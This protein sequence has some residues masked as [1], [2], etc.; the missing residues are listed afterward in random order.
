MTTTH[1]PPVPTGDGVPTGSAAG[2][3]D[4]GTSGS[5]APGVPTGDAAP[6][7]S[8]AG[9]AGATDPGARGADQAGRRPDPQRTPLSGDHLRA[10]I[11]EVAADAQYPAAVSDTELVA[12]ALI[13]GTSVTVTLSYP[14]GAEPS[15]T[16]VAVYLGRYD[17][18][19]VQVPEQAV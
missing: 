19:V 14:L 13:A 15:G 17:V 1:V 2:T 11:A 12:S 10:E 5:A 9:A 16:T 8:A 7:G 6:T 4:L 3:T 18:T